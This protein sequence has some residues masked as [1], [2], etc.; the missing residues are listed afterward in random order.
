MTELEMLAQEGNGAVQVAAAA[1]LTKPYPKIVFLCG[2]ICIWWSEWDSP[3]HKIYTQWRDAVRAA[4]IHAGC[5]VYSPHRAISGSWHP[6]AQ[7]INDAA[8]KISD[9]VVNMTPP[10]V[11][12]EGTEKELHLAIDYQRTIINAPPGDENELHALIEKIK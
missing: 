3:R 11:S 8:I 4:L 2:P 10:G 5:L 9:F 12:G 7:Q 1:D 6:F